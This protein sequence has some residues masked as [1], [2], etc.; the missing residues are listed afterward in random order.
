MKKKYIKSCCVLFAAFLAFAATAQG[1]E[2]SDTLVNVAFRT[3]AKEDLLGGVST[4]NVA[5]LLKKNYSSNSLDNLQSLVGGYANGNIWGQ[6]PLILIDGVPRRAADVRLTEVESIT[7]LKGASA[8]VLYGSNASKGAILITTKRGTISPLRIDVRA[9]T[10]L[11]V[12]KSYP[13]YLGAADYMTYYNEA[14]TNDGILVNGTSGYTQ[15]AID[16]SRI[17]YNPFRY[18][19]I[20][21]FSSDYLK[22]TFSKS[23]ITTE[24]AGGNEFA[25]YYTNIGLTSNNDIVNY[26]EQK[27][28][29]DFGFNV[30]GNVDMTISKWLTASANAV[31]NM[32]DNYVGRGN[33]WAA[34]AT[35]PPN[36][37]R[38]SPLFPIDLIQPTD[39]KNFDILTIAKNS[40]HI[41][42]GK[43]L[44]GGLANAPTN[45]FADML[46]AGYIK[47]KLRTFLYN[48]NAK[49]D[50]AAFTKG[51]SF[52]AG[53]SMDYTSA[54]TE[55]YS[56]TYAT[57]EPIWSTVNG[58]EVITDFRSSN[59]AKQYSV[60]QN[61]TTENIGRTIY[62]QTMSFKSQFDYARTFANDHNV[63]ATALGWWYTSQYS[64][65]TDNGGGTYQP[66]KNTNLGLQA[67]YNFRKK[68]Y[69]DFSGALIHSAKLPPGKRDGISPTVT[70]GWRLSD[71]QFFK[72]NLSFFNNLKLTSS[73]ASIKQDLDVTG[74]RLGTTADYYLYQTNFTNRI[75]AGYYQWRDGAPGAGG[76]TTRSVAS[77][78]PDL[79]FV[80]R[81]EFRVG[82][83]GAMLSNVIT[84]DANYFD[85]ITDGL[86][87]QVGSTPFPSYF[88]GVGDFRPWLNYGKQKRTGVDFAINLNKRIGEVQ[89]SLGVTG[90]FYNSKVQRTFETPQESYLAVTNR[91]LD[92][93]F[94][95][96]A[97]GFYQNQA[98]ITNSA[99][100]QFGGS[101]KPGDI[102]YKDI[103]GDGL[104]NQNDQITLGKNGFASSP[105]NYGVNL[106]V[107]WKRLTMFALASGNTGSVAFKNSSYYWPSATG[108]YSEE[109]LN[110][111]T[112]ATAATATYPRLSTNSTANNYRNSTFWMYKTNRFNLSRVQFTY[113]FNDEILK[114]SFVHGL[115]VYVQGD[116]LLVIAKERKLMETNIG[117]APQ[118]RFF[119]LGVR[120]SF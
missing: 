16:K 71:E 113:D 47:T 27:K 82:L 22:K 114:K 17:G 13:K 1:Q 49:A 62:T 52:T 87:S 91:P 92:N 28:N 105:F 18:P 81:N 12:P 24:I 59:G 11:F 60:D 36:F 85:Q 80:K 4:V 44:L 58:N 111:W 79:T 115:S 55:G 3:V 74:T 65:D 69:I 93:V 37:N 26:G 106:T 45:V 38:Y 102:K 73:Y 110:R 119:N 108:P 84:F 50:L 31:A 43:Y 7:V 98:D 77:G 104:I 33:F 88:S 51:L 118:Y 101:I 78:N 14:L 83:E 86:L 107:K 109:V 39:P 72:K 23:D 116:N 112:P 41:I 70:V 117:T 75:G 9:N 95:Y 6:S 94:G 34:S 76:N 8:V 20:N 32:A 64:A 90:L 67:G 21:F 48:V 5:E 46:A 66:L 10:G 42:D 35:T 96:V 103:N 99:K 97:D 56:L 63:T 2:K 54:Y 61:S 30:R 40:N 53:T 29:R 89:Y 19:D 15:D 25:R 120:T 57:Y 100:P 68:Y